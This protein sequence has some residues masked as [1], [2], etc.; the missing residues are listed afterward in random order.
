MVK[1]LIFEELLMAFRVAHT[2]CDCLAKR[3]MSVYFHFFLKRSLLLPSL[4]VRIGS[5][6]RSKFTLHPIHPRI[7]T[8]MIV[9]D[10]L[11]DNLVLS[12]NIHHSIYLLFIVCL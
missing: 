7:R 9:F 6:S 2:V 1:S 12:L 10:V 8:W 4:T 11:V 5:V 3:S